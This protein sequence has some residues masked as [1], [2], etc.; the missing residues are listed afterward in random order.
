V[1]GDRKGGLGK[2]AIF[3]QYLTISWKRY[4]TAVVKWNANRKKLYILFQTVP[5]PMTS[6]ILKDY[7]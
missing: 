6:V 1:N 2:S 3:G 7:F 5:F 4:K